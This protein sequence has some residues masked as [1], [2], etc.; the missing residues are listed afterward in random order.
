[1][2]KELI[3]SLLAE[4]KRSGAVICARP[5]TATVKK[6]DLKKNTIMAT[7]DREKLFLAQTPQVFKKKLL[8]DRYAALGKKALARTDEAALFDGSKTAVRVVVGP[9]MNIKI[10]TP[11]DLKL[12]EFYLK[13]YSP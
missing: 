4:A 5:A 7:E 2:T 12:S 8:E 10:T 9:H 3:A 6:V 13:S 1:V 11:E